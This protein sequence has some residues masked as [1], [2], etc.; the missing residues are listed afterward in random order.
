M[1]YVVNK[2]YLSLVQNDLRIKKFQH[3]LFMYSIKN[4]TKINVLNKV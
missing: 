1:S 4:K 3:C 2:L